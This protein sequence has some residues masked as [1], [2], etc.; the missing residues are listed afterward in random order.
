MVPG[1]RPASDHCAQR[2]FFGHDGAYVLSATKPVLAFES[3]IC[4]EEL[5]HRFVGALDQPA[6]AQW[7]GD[8]EIRD[9]V[10]AHSEKLAR[11]AQAQVLLGNAK[12]VAL[13]HQHPEPFHRLRTEVLTRHEKAVSLSST[14]APPAP[15]RV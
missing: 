13:V 15:P 11:A 5:S 1:P 9:A 6:V 3:R 14:P 4:I 7:I 12:P 2:H 8:L 10:L